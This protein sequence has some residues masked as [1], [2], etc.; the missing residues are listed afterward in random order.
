MSTERPR[1][2]R[3]TCAPGLTPWLAAEVEALGFELS[4]SDHTGV[5]TSGTMVDAMRLLLNLRTAFHVL[6]RFA[7]IYPRDADD[8]YEQ[9]SGLPWERVIPVDGY[10]SVVSVVQNDTIRNSM[11]P[12]VRPKDAIVDRLQRIHGLGCSYR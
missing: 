3:A 6:Q 5:E 4:G 7:D 1:S 12:N 10:L 11:F 9:A 8:L 2:L